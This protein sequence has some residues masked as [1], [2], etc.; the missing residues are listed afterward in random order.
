MVSLN[1][2]RERVVVGDVMNMPF[3][4]GSFDLVVCSALLHHLGRGEQEKAVR[5]F[6]RVSRGFVAVSEPHWLNP[7]M[8]LFGLLKKE[9]RGI[10]GLRKRRI[11]ELFS[12]AGLEVTR[13]KV[14]GLVLPNLMARGLLRPVLPVASAL[15][16]T[17][18]AAVLG[19]HVLVIGR[20]A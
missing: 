9:E 2:C 14:Y 16:R 13:E 7:A 19:F 6:A 5:E 18:L 8:F 10:I 4:D 3:A 15:A 17:W 11:R 12:R 1:P 20:K